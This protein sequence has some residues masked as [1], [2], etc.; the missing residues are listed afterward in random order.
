MAEIAM[1]KPPKFVYDSA[2]PRRLFYDTFKGFW[3]YR[4]LVGILLKRDISVRYKRSVL[5]LLWTLLNP[6]LTSVILWFVFINS[7]SQRLPANV[8]FASYVLAG[9]LLISF[10]T[11]G[12]RLAS[13]SIPVNAN[14]L[15]KVYVPPQI[16]PFATATFA[17]FNFVMGLIA[18]VILSYATGGS[19]SWL[20][21]VTIVLIVLMIFFVTGLALILSVAHIRFVDTRDITAILISFTMFVTP[22]FYPKEILSGAMVT[23][24][25]LNPLTSFLDILRHYFLNSGSA[26]LNDWLYVS[27]ASTLALLIGIRVFAK[28]WPRLVVML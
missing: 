12:L 11:L 15:M 14:I 2:A 25:N 20:F 24:V 22:V 16:F 8:S 27:I 7:F 5:G 3:E 23:I 21:P 10:F 26:S 17:A 19:I 1:S 4:E 9:V 28:S 6:L 18:L 13:E